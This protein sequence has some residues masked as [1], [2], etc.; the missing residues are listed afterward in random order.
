MAAPK[1]PGFRPRRP[2]INIPLNEHIRARTLRVIDQHGENLGELSKDEALAIARESGLDLYVVSDKAE[3]PIARILDYGKYKFEQSKKEKT[4]K[5]QSGGD[6]KEIKMGYNID[7]GDYNTR[8]NHSKKFLDKGKRVK[9]NITLKGREMQH[10]D[11]AKLL[12]ERFLNDLMDHGT[13]DPVPDRMT[14]RSI[15]V[16]IVPGPD[17]ARIKKRKEEEAAKEAET[18]ARGE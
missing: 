3:K 12:A 6:Y 13:G 15:I 16:Y 8:I 4:V 5:K 7:V 2:R 14:G 1:R 11:R 17:K 10:A 9:L 18:N